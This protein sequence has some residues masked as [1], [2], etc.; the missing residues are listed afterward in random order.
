M[1][2][3]ILFSTNL[4]GYAALGTF[5]FAFICTCLALGLPYWQYYDITLG[6]QQTISNHGLWRYCIDYIPDTTALIDVCG[7]PVDIA[8]GSGATDIRATRAFVI[9]S[10]ILEIAGI[11]CTVLVV[12]V[13]KFKK[14]YPFH[15][16]AAVCGVASG[17]F[18]MLGLAVYVA[19]VRNDD[20]DLHAASALQ[21]LSWLTSWTSSGFI[22]YMMIIKKQSD[23]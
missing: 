20:Y 19:R 3:P 9:I 11:L 10:V 12:F 21:I 1:K 15:Y 22:V 16:A 13:V 6:D 23:E 8:T 18:S 4:L 17:F 2:Q 5:G 14:N 7:D